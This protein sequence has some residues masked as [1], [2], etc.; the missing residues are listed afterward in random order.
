MKWGIL[1]SLFTLS[2]FKFMFAPFG[3][4]GLKLSFMETYL[5]CVSGATFSAAIFYF[6]AEYFL[7]RARRKRAAFIEKSLRTGKRIKVKKTFTRMNKLI[8]HIKT[9]LGII[10]TCFWVPLFLSI[11]LGSIVTAKFYSRRRKTFPLIV[12]GIFLNALVT[13]T[14]SYT[15]YG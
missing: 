12:V 8:V 14:I 1:F 13:T 9:K 11:P 2:T 3:G 5:T 10:G 6:S 15:I 7:N 4:P